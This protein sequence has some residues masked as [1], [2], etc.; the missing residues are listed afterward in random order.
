MRIVFLMK[1]VLFYISR[2]TE[3]I[4]KQ[5]LWKNKRTVSNR[6][7]FVFKL[8]P[9]WCSSI[10]KD[11]KLKSFTFTLKKERKGIDKCGS[12]KDGLESKGLE[13]CAI[14][15]WR[16]HVNKTIIKDYLRT[17]VHWHN[18]KVSAK[19]K[20]IWIYKQIYS[21]THTSSSISICKRFGICK[22]QCLLLSNSWP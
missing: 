21:N 1:L 20:I 16:V 14:M 11:L 9:I 4:L 22:Y 17:Q 13:A 3:L 19:H 12:E 8:N 6:I 10:E 2:V 18:R 5:R 7:R 15:N